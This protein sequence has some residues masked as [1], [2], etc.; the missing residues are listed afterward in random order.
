MGYTPMMQQYFSVKEQYKDCILFYRLGDFYEMFFD[1]AL[2]A[3]RELEL[4]LTG[5]DCGMPERAPMCGVPYHSSSGYVSKLIAKGYK[6]AICEQVEDP[7]VAKGIV[8]R[9]VIRVV[10]PS[11]ITEDG[12]VESDKNNFLASVY[13]TEGRLGAAFLDFSTGELYATIIYNDIYENIITELS[14]FM[15]TECLVN[16][17]AANDKTIDKILKASGCYVTRRSNEYFEDSDE[18]N[19]QCFEGRCT[20]IKS[21]ISYNAI[22]AAV[23]YISETQKTDIS[24]INS[25]SYYSIGEFMNMDVNT[26]RNLELTETM[27]TKKKKGSLLWVL[28]MTETSM[29]G[30]RLRSWVEQPLIN[31][32]AIN[33]RLGG[34]EELFK[35]AVIRLNIRELLKNVM[36]MERL[37]S[38]VV[39]RSANARDLLALKNSFSI[40]PALL[41]E[42]AGCKSEIINEL[43]KSIDRLE[44]ICGLIDMS[45]CDNPPMTIRDGGII[46]EN[47][48]ERLD[49]YRA[50]LR[51]G[52]GWL[53]DI[54]AKEK[55]NTGIKNLKVGF[56]KVFGYYIEVSKSNVDKVPES[57]IR[58][59]TLTNGERYITQELKEIEDKILGAEEKSIQL[60]YM[61][62]EE[63]R[64]AVGKERE[65]IQNT[66]KAIGILDCLMSLA[67]VAAKYNYVRPTVDV[68]DVIDIKQGR[69]PVVERLS[70]EMFVPND[71]F[72]NNTGDRLSIITGPNMAGKSTYMRQVAV[73]ALMAQIGSFVPAA[74]ARI[75][76]SDSIF[77]RVGASDDLAAGQSTFMVEMSEVAHILKN[78]TQ[79]SLIIYDEIGRGTSTYDGLAIAWAVLEYTAS[80]KTCGAKTLF[81][82]HYH[83][84]TGLEE[85]MEGVKNYSVAIKERGDDIVFLRK[86]VSGG[87]DNSYGVD[88]AKL[89]GLPEDVIKRARAILKNLEG[90]KTVLKPKKVK[91]ESQPQMSFAA[92]IES[93]IIEKIKSLD[94]DTLT[95]IEGLSF[96][97]KIKKE[98]E[99][100]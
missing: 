14:R 85:S 66:A 79:N 17:D 26:R 53:A 49:G 73:I 89:A 99:Q 43:Y 10:T 67:E 47:Y 97:Y 44:D 13:K 82:T 78:A 72:L 46:K 75:G 1:D 71:T 68:S 98:L 3:S 4:T 74:S 95:P 61:L 54:E 52:K 20:L 42:I 6:V 87:A 9:D 33:K 36:D 59:Q 55:E 86:I 24:H 76:I 19:S 69:H 90:G 91:E 21:E 81:A 88:V 15:P 30:R 5:R 64:E 40:I 12:V 29:G 63:I 70:D 39:C 100:I 93:E 92:G 28:D 83:E 34:V 77:T 62:F 8:K 27:R 16:E 60:E 50:A 7:A 2:T 65:R 41:F 25:V 94:V 57:Y 32:G 11:T 58:K 51:D 38:K 84:L 45:I 18:V 23:K 31:C 80:K 35:N 96:L 37:I 22:G 56:N 48:S